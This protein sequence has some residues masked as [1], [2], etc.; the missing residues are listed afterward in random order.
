MP[1]QRIATPFGL[2]DVAIAVIPAAPDTTP[3]WI[4]IPSVEAAAF[5]LNVEE[6]EQYGDDRYQ[7]TFYHSQ[8]GTITV[9]GNKLSMR[10]FELLTGTSVT[11][12]GATESMYFGT[13]KELIPP[14]VMVRAIVPLRL[15]DGTPSEMTIYWFNADVKTSWDSIPG[16]ERAKLA[17][18]SLMFNSYASTKDERGNTI[19]VEV[20]SAFG[21]FII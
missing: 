18:V 3:V 5:K 4:D 13:E 14:R 12:S 6:V 20:G 17:E 21:R 11:S 1:A 7:G 15:E 16:G 19:P 10:V 8:K 9:K 2:R